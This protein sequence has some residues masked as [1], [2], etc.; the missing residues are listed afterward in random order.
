MQLHLV[1]K[2]A[3]WPQSGNEEIA[4]EKD[5]RRKRTSTHFL[6]EYYFLPSK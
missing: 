6:A 3:V 4:K 5:S 1:T 2:P